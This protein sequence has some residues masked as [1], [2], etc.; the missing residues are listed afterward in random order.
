MSISAW[1]FSLDQCD[2][3]V[4]FVQG[5]FLSYYLDVAMVVSLLGHVCMCRWRRPLEVCHLGF[6]RTLLGVKELRKLAS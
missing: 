6:G 5:Y 3:R 1:F 2:A 4:S